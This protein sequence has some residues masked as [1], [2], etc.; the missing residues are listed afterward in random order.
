M[1]RCIL[2]P[3]NL[4][5]NPCQSINALPCALAGQRVLCT[6]GYAVGLCASASHGQSFTT[7]GNPGP[8]INAFQSA[9][10]GRYWHA[11]ERLARS[12][13]SWGHGQRGPSSPVRQHPLPAWS[14]VHV[15]ALF[16]LPA[17]KKQRSRRCSKNRAK[18]SPTRAKAERRHVPD[19]DTQRSACPCRAATPRAAKARAR[20]GERNRVAKGKTGRRVEGPRG[21]GKRALKHQKTCAQ[22]AHTQTMQTR[23]LFARGAFWRG[24]T[25]GVLGPPSSLPPSFARQHLAALACQDLAVRAAAPARSRLRRRRGRRLCGSGRRPASFARQGFRCLSST[26][27]LACHHPRCRAATAKRGKHSGA[28]V[29]QYRRSGGETTRSRAQSSH[30]LAIARG[31]GSALT[32]FCLLALGSTCL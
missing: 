9:L 15:F 19:A 8:S 4:V 21:A 10:A 12:C 24:S 18:S 26:F 25:A 31:S 1:R 13:R 22:H 16:A 23:R 11:V 30:A 5:A 20:G 6:S 17:Q 7:T 2:V 32:A 29:Q 3:C 28:A 27:P 14:Q